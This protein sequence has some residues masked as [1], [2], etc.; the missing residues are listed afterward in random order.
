MREEYLSTVYVFHLRV[1]VS[2]RRKEVSVGV[3]A[4]HGDVTDRL[5]EACAQKD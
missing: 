1:R 4:T 3:V 5:P 2:L